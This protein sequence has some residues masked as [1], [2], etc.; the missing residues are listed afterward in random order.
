MR[1]LTLLRILVILLGVG[2]LIMLIPLA[3]A[4]ILGEQRMI[5][6]L[7]LPAGIIIAAAL[8]AFFSYRKNPLRFRARDGFLL[9][10]LTWVGMSLLGAMPFY[11]SAREFSFTNAFFESACGFATTGATTITDVEAL[12]KSLLLWR[13]ISHWVGGMGIVLLTVALMPL[14]GVGGFQLIKAEVSGPEKERIT[15]KITATAKVMWFTYCILTA[16]LVI[17]F[18]IG[19]M[20]WLDAFCHSFTTM[21]SGGISTKN[22]GL[23]WY[24]S[25]FIDHV[26]MVFMLLAG[27]NFNLYFRLARGKFKDI[28]TN[29]EAR[30]YLGIFLI[31]AAA[32]TFT[33]IP[34][35]G[36]LSASWRFGAF[37]AA[38]ILSTTGAVI[39]DY[40]VWPAFAQAILFALMFVGGCSSSTA[41]GIKVIRHVVLW[42]QTGNE[43]R[44]ILFPQGVFSIQLNK[45]VGRKDVVYGVSAFVFLYAAVVTIVALITAASGVDIFSSFSTALSVI[46]NIGVG[47]GAI[48]PGHNFGAFPDQLKWLYSFAMIAGRLELWTVLILFTPEYWRR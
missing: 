40:S 17:L 43:L 4:L 1:T 44:R 48:G 32:I 2:A 28:I 29:T 37:H 22:S 16:V 31:S 8:P 36:S 23:S 24:N 25:A 5:W 14:L 34:V 10:F 26:T 13:S 41:G 18:R 12:P 20:E 21:A 30:V 11:L 15:P 9:V 33:L 42:K 46:S 35:Y 6:A 27:L 7:G 39:A 38:S 45:K 47:F 19:G 3:L